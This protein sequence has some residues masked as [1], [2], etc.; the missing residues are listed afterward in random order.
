MY[1]LVLDEAEMRVLSIAVQASVKALLNVRR[2]GEHKEDE[3][4][5]NEMIV[6][7]TDLLAAIEQAYENPSE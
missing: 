1:T 6:V 7:H 2:K 5:I 3:P 4:V